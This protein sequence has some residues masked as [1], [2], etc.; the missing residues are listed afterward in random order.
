MKTPFRFFIVSFA[1]TFML[2][3]LEFI[4]A[5][6]YILFAIGFGV[7][8]ICLLLEI[9]NTPKIAT[10]VIY[11]IISVFA[12]IGWIS[13]FANTI[14]D[15]IGFLAFYFSISKVVLTTILLSIGNSIGDFFG[16]AALA[17]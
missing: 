9:L 3:A 10:D 13:L 1:L 6:W 12:A 17:K 11:E 8:L 7:G 2:W 15:F 16:N 5:E 14:I 4:D